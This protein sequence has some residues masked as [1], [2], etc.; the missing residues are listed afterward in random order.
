MIVLVAM[1]AM[2][3][4]IAASHTVNADVTVTSMMKKTTV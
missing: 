2:I 4:M 1:A 3:A